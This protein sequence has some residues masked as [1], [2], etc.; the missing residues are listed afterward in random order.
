MDSDKLDAVYTEI[1]QKESEVKMHL[2]WQ[3]LDLANFSAL[4]QN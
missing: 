3:I 1:F 2:P 4:N